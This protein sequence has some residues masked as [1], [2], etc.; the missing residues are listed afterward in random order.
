MQINSQEVLFFAKI[1]SFQSFSD[2]AF[3]LNIPQPT[4]SRKILD[5]EAKLNQKLFIRSRRGITLSEFGERFLQGS[6]TLQQEL[7]NLKALAAGHSRWNKTVVVEALQSLSHLLICDFLPYFRTHFPDIVVD[8]RT[9]HNRQQGQRLGDHLRLQTNTFDHSTRTFIH[10]MSASRSFYVHPALITSDQQDQLRSPE[11]IQRHH[12]PCISIHQ[13]ENASVRWQYWRDDKLRELTVKP[14]LVVDDAL[15]ARDAVLNRLGVSW[16]YDVLMQSAI[17]TGQA[18]SLFRQNNS[19][20]EHAYI[21]YN[22]G[23]VLSEHET[24]FINALKGYYLDKVSESIILGH[25]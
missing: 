19:S 7:D 1:A 8:V 18:I 20:R 13:A 4:I 9:I 6:D 11:D 14:L 5:L 17:R 21:A 2:A 25:S 15:K 10:Y 22:N 23:K 12:L 3:S 24:K 16:N